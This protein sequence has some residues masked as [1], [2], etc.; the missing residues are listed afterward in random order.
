[1]ADG[2][3]ISLSAGDGNTSCLHRMTAYQSSIDSIM[4]TCMCQ[5]VFSQLDNTY[6]RA[7]F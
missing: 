4:E 3:S 5:K 2:L 1:M 6:D 7:A